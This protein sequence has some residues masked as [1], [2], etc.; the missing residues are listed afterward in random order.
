MSWL[1]TVLQYLY[2]LIFFCFTLRPLAIT[3]TCLEYLLGPLIHNFSF[4]PFSYIRPLETLFISPSQSLLSAWL[5]KKSSM[6]FEACYYGFSSLWYLNPRGL[7]CL[8]SSPVSSS[9]DLEMHL[10][11]PYVYYSCSQMIQLITLSTIPI[12]QVRLNLTQK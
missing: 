3:T 7:H 4:C 5:L 10:N 6:E 2:R 11:F 9:R 8:D 12:F 1:I